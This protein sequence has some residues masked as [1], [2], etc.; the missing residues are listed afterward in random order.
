MLQAPDCLG[1]SF[2]SLLQLVLISL[3]HWGFQSCTLLQVHTQEYQGGG[4]NHF[5]WSAGYNLA[6]AA[7]ATVIFDLHCDVPLTQVQFVHQKPRSFFCWARWHPVC[8]AD[9][10]HPT[11]NATLTTHPCPSLGFMSAHSSS[12]PRLVW[13]AALPF[14]ML[15]NSPNLVSSVRLVR[16]HSI[17]QNNNAVIKQYHSQA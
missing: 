1:V 11:P 3:L 12:L 10:D 17:V 14:G 8:A 9:W 13:V 6:N 4:N 16:V 5:P 7:W 15:G 2:L